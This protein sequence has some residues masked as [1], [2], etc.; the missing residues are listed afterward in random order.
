VRATTALAIGL[1]RVIC[2]RDPAAA[3]ERDRRLIAE[4]GGSVET[5]VRQTMLPPLSQGLLARGT[6]GAGEIFPQPTVVIDGR[7]VLLDDVTGCRMRVVVTDR[8]D[9]HEVRTL[10]TA[11][12]QIGGVVLVLGSGGGTAAETGCIVVDETEPLV[13]EWLAA[14]G[15]FGGIVRPDHVVFGTADSGGALLEL[16][17][18]FTSQVRIHA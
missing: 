7:T 8:A 10:S 16:L 14:L 15:S 13:A 1:G 18:L 12:A 17:E 11:V 5:T 3:V 2:E 9:V 6:P 4:Y